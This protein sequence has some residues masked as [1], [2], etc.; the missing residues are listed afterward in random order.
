MVNRWR[1]VHCYYSFPTIFEHLR[2]SMTK[3]VLRVRLTSYWGSSNNEGSTFLYAL[4]LVVACFFPLSWSR[5]GR[6]ADQCHSTMS[7]TVNRLLEPVYLTLIL[8][9]LS[10]HRDSKTRLISYRLGIEG[11]LTRKGI[12]YISIEYRTV[13]WKV[14]L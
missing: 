1:V 5:Y 6:R 4:C 7:L 8:E 2:S 11:C 12:W 3:Q 10:W 14:S 9:F 13:K